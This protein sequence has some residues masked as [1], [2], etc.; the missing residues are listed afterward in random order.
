M[1]AVVEVS[2]AD[3]K[4]KMKKKVKAVVEEGPTA[5]SSCS[6][7]AKK[8]SKKIKA[9]PVT[10]RAYSEKA[11]AIL[12]KRKKLPCWPVKSEFL[13]LVEKNRVV[14]LVG[15]TGCFSPLVRGIILD[16]FL[17]FT[18]RGGPGIIKLEV[19]GRISEMFPCSLFFRRSK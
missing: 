14:V 4:K 8:E 7:A 16:H 2:K 12:K 17:Y 13:E 19:V 18:G 6:K 15:E 11:L 1:A 5:L 10:G 3:E 9:D